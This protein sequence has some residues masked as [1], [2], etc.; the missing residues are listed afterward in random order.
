MTRPPTH[1]SGLASQTSLRE[2]PSSHSQVA[3]S[4][5]REE[6]L[7]ERT[8]SV[9]ARFEHEQG[10]G[11]GA[12]D[13]ILNKLAAS[14]DAFRELMANLTEGTKVRVGPGC[15][16]TLTSAKKVPWLFI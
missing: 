9:H 4:L 13:E 8:D 11:G 16:P 3:D 1:W 7:V 10:Q 15:E 12:R 14:F 6:E 5:E 2:N